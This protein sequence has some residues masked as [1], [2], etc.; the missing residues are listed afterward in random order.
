MFMKH[1]A[2]S[3]LLV[4]KDG[5]F[6][7]TRFILSLKLLAKLL[8]ILYQLTKFEAPTY[9]NFFRYLYHC[10]V[11][12]FSYAPLFQGP[13]F[14]TKMLESIILYDNLLIDILFVC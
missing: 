8:I 7:K 14:L 6:F 2:P 10:T 11:S 5:A 13:Y 9:N 12:H 3:H 1:C 4:H